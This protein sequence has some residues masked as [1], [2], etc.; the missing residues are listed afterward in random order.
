MRYFFDGGYAKYVLV[1]L[2]II[3]PFKSQLPWETLGAIPEMFQTVSGSLNQALE[4]QAGEILLLRGGTF[5][6]WHVSLSARQDKR[7][8][9][10]FHYKKS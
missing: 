8:T 4:I 10:C 1:P 3:F 2:E 6:Y 5:L 7:A 9:R